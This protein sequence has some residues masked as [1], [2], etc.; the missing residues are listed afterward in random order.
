MVR[1]DV[2]NRESSVPCFEGPWSTLVAIDISTGTKRWEVPAGQLKKFVG[3]PQAAQWGSPVNQGG[4]I[5]TDTGVVFL[6]TRFDAML[7]AF[8]AQ[9]GAALWSNK[10]PAQPQATPMSYTLNG[11]SYVVVTAGGWD[12]KDKNK[13]GDYVIAFKVSSPAGDRAQGNQTASNGS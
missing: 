6:A 4:P 11:T 3:H 8:D 5:T 1:F 10:L 9:T 12:T 2:F 13:R 7:H